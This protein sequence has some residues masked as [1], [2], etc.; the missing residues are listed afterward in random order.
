M[1]KTIHCP[2]CGVSLNVPDAAVGR[3]LKCP[4]CGVKFS[5]DGGP[6][7]VRA[8]SSPGT[9][10]DAG[11]GS[12]ITLPT[13]GGHG[14][15][16]LPTA[17]GDLRDTFD[18]ASLGEDRPVGRAASVAD[19]LALFKDDDAVSRRRKT[20]A[21]GRAHARRCPTCGGVVPQGMSIC[22]TCGLDLETGVRIDLADTLD[23]A[24]GPM[25]PT[26]PPMGIWIVGLISMAVSAIFAI[27]SL[28]HW[29]KGESGYVFLL[30]VCGFGAYAGVQ[31]LR[32]KSVKL[33]LIALT[34]GVF[35][36]VVVLIALPIYNASVQIDIM[37]RNVDPNL[38][39]DSDIAIGNIADHLDANQLTAGIAILMSYAALAVYLNSPAVRR[40]Y[41]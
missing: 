25:R 31:F 27:I 29:I 17:S 21:E 30:L 28:L 23:A 8:G 35:V 15:L 24:P 13:S 39:D 34:L 19:P 33:L 14:D 26:G 1:S 38:P 22:G 37:Q 6:A 7:P 5:A 9:K 20:A 40:Y 16:D 11:R 36:D 10:G 32:L 3:R 4:K 41:R 18:F 2:E 12:S